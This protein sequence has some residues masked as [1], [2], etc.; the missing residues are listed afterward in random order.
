MSPN[1]HPA[2]GKSEVRPSIAVLGDVAVDLTLDVPTFPRVGGDAFAS[3]QRMGVGGC[4]TNA[5]ITLGRIGARPTLTANVGDDDWGRSAVA[6]LVDEGVDVSAISYDPD[7]PTHL[8]LIIV[9][10][11]GERTMIGHRGSSARVGPWQPLDRAIAGSHALLVS[12]Y[13]LFGE[14]RAAQ[15]IKAIHRSALLGIPVILDLPTDLPT[16]IQDLASGLLS[17]VRVLVVGGREISDLTGIPNPSAAAESLA[18]ATLTVIATLGAEGAI[19]I[20]P[21]GQ[22]RTTGHQVRVLD[23]TGSGDAFVAAFTASWL[24]GLALADAVALA[25]AFGAAAA[26]KNG[27]GTAMPTPHDVLRLIDAT[28]PPSSEAARWLQGVC[29]T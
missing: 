19:A 18:T 22:V 2:L 13:A 17:E 7:T 23:T 28:E 9:S 12:G 5:A 10:G 6:S 8:T 21:E 27:A 20:G 4:G 24:E 25:N 16:G 3:S 29:R 26:L 15:A 14:E 1:G 11:D